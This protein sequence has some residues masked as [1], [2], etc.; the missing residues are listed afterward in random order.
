MAFTPMKLRTRA[1]PTSARSQ[2]LGRRLK[3]EVEKF[4]AQY[5]GTSQEELRAAAE[6]AIGVAG[7]RRP[8][9]AVGR[10]FGL[11]SVA[12]AVVG[13]MFATAAARGESL[14]VLFPSVIALATSSMVIAIVVAIRF[15]KRSR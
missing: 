10:L 3:E 15:R 12:A 7:S 14:R 9:R 11:L 13:G 6:I 2:D 1:D 5:P 4:E 8:P